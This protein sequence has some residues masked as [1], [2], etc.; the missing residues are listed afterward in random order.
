MSNAGWRA[1]GNEMPALFALRS[2]PLPSISGQS[3]VCCLLILRDMRLVRSHLLQEASDKGL[4]STERRGEEELGD[5]RYGWVGDWSHIHG[6]PLS[7][8]LLL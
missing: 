3:G 6:V 1:V 2:F 4:M 7:P 5:C 8:G